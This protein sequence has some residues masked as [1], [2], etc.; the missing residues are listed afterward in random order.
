MR[1]P[2][3]VILMPLSVIL[4][5]HFWHWI[6]LRIFLGAKDEAAPVKRLPATNI[7]TLVG[8]CNQDSEE[9]S[10]QGDD[11]MN[12]YY[13]EQMDEMEREEKEFQS[14]QFD[15]FCESDRAEYEKSQ[16]LWVEDENF[17]K[18][19]QKRIKL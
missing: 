15:Y 10:E 19:M 13:I 8:E 17:I 14:S 11:A 1:V 18:E 5:R 6:N 12:D 3:T 9:L 4:T 7:R 16:E 2:R